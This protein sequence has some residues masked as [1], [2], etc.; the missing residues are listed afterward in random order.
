MFLFFAQI[1]C[2]ESGNCVPAE[3]CDHGITQGP[4]PKI[5]ENHFHC[6][7]GGECEQVSIP[8]PFFLLVILY[9]KVTIY[10]VGLSPAFGD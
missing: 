9:K 1:F 4:N 7:T 8:T 3:G 6:L 5:D 10:I 2:L